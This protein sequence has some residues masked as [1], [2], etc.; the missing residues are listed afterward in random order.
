VQ[1]PVCTCSGSGCVDT[2]NQLDPSCCPAGTQCDG[3]GQCL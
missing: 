3:S 2:C 1:V